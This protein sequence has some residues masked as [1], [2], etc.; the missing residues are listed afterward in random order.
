[1]MSLKKLADSL[2]STNTSVSSK[3]YL[4]EAK[5]AGNLRNNP[6]FPVQSHALL[7]PHLLASAYA[8]AAK[9]DEAQTL[10]SLQ[11]AFDAGFTDFASLKEHE[12]IA[13]YKSQAVMTLINTRTANYKQELKVWARNSI[14]NFQSFQ[15]KFD[16]ADIDAGRIRNSDYQGRILVLDLWA[17]WCQPCREA[18]PDFVK[19]DEKFRDDNVDVVG[20][21]MD[22]PDDPRRSLKVVRK[23]VDK[24]NVEYAVAMGNRSVLNQLAPG[25]KLPTVLF[26]DTQGQVRYIA[27]GPHNFCQLS[28]ITDQLLE[29]E[30]ESPT[31]VPAT[32]SSAW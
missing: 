8:H 22:S 26:I 6:G 13:G 29:M 30:K 28:A 20:I 16:V 25:Q 3:L 18:I 10:A 4:S 2:V 1:M 32:K 31:S 21:S 17:T 23:F 27:E 7:A 9:K 5:I 24:S 15:F 11:A 12:M 19:L 14:T